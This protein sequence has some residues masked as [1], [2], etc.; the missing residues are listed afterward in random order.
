MGSYGGGDWEE[1]QRLGGV[2]VIAR[3]SQRLLECAR[4]WMGVPDI[5]GRG[6]QLR[7]RDRDWE[8]DR[9]PQNGRERVA[10]IGKERKCQR[11]GERECR[12][13]GARETEIG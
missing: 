1:C 5:G 3:V 2:P 10:D 9:L 12:R 4:D 6:R 11:L 8:R 7:E 13:L